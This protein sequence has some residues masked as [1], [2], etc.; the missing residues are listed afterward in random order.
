MDNNNTFTEESPYRDTAHPY[1]DSTTYPYW[2]K[3]ETEESMEQRKLS[4]TRL[5]PSCLIYAIFLTFCI[6]KNLSGVTMP[7]FMVGTLCFYPSLLRC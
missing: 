3:Y 2:M 5:I 1:A 4:A 6:Y 7:V